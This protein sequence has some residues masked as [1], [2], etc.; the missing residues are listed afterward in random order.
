MSSI[1]GGVGGGS[2]TIGG[3]GRL[4]NAGTI[5]QSKSS[6]SQLTFHYTI[7]ISNDGVYL[8]NDGTHISFEKARRPVR[9]PRHDSMASANSSVMQL[10]VIGSTLTNTTGAKITGGAVHV[11]GGRLLGVS[12]INSSVV[13]LNGGSVEPGF[14]AGKLDVYQFR[15]ATT[16]LLKIELGGATPG[17]EYDQLEATLS[18]FLQGTLD[19]SEVNGFQVACGQAFD[20]VLH[21]MASGYGTFTN[22]TGLAPGSGRGLRIVYLNNTATSQGKVRLVA[23]DPGLKV[24]IGPNPVAIA[25]GGPST[26]YAVTLGNAPT[27]SVTVTATPNSQVTVTPASLTFTTSNWQ[28]PQ[29]FTVTA[30][31]DNVFE[32]DHTGNVGHA[33]TSTDATY[34]GYAVAAL[35]A[36][37]T[38]ND[39]APP[40]AVDDN[41]QTAAPNAVI[42]SVLTNDSDPDGQALTVTA[43]TQPA[44]GS[45][46]ISGGGTTVTYTPNATFGGQD[47]FTYTISDGNGGTATGSV[48]VNVT[49][50]NLA[51][52]AVDDSR[53]TVTGNAVIV[54]VL[55]NDSDPDSDPLTIASVTQ[56]AHGTAQI[57]NV[58]QRVIYTPAAGYVG[59][60]QFTYTVSDGRGG[61][62]TA[63]V[64]ITVNPPVPG[65]QPPIA[66]ADNFSLGNGS[67][68]NLN[69]LAN[70]SDP[71]GDALR[72]VAVT[73]P[74]T[75]HMFSSNLSINRSGTSLTYTVQQCAVTPLGQFSYTVSD[76]RGG[77]ATQSATFAL[78]PPAR[79]ICLDSLVVSYTPGSTPG[80]YDLEVWTVWR[81]NGA[82]NGQRVAILVDYPNGLSSSQNGFC[83]PVGRN[84]CMHE[85]TPILAFGG[86][87]RA[88]TPWRTVVSQS[89]NYRFTVSLVDPVTQRVFQD[90]DTRNNRSMSGS[91]RI[92]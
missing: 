52:I 61:S 24:C 55:A 18:A 51:P 49:A 10:R 92:P 13:P 16:G 3:S 22:V 73:Q 89:G 28:Q 74:N 86:F 23:Y 27:A 2:L 1:D 71:D 82:W 47:A 37:I 69:V 29:F 78:Q 26:Q 87:G 54:A 40:V 68:F 84:Q 5:A 85:I 43:V 39:N 45:A 36:N 4:T 21:P 35:T 80:T 48:F 44:N 56:P 30:V 46:Q 76:G 83:A 63:T 50:P 12:S 62:A 64:S 57:D 79:D 90:F 31:D 38:D 14:S 7:E 65:N 6:G 8:G 9:K 67:S 72:I 20:V 19:I 11:D 42:V 75:G 25:E 88:R 41:A 81:P 70:D 77:T 17:T 59:A 91:V 66:V 32:G 15:P 60:D 34:S 33:V 58:T 53:Q